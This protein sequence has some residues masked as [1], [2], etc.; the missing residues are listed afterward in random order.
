MDSRKTLTLEARLA[1]TEIVE[2]GQP[3][4]NVN[5]DILG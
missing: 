5:R 1:F 3:G 2:K 4:G